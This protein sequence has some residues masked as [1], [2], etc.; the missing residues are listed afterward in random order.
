[1]QRP[2]GTVRSLASSP[3]SSLATSSSSSPNQSSISSLIITSSSTSSS[4][5]FTPGENRPDSNLKSSSMDSSFK[6]GNTSQ[7][8]ESNTISN[9]ATNNSLSGPKFLWPSTV[10]SQQQANNNKNEETN[11]NKYTFKP[12]QLPHPSTISNGNQQRPRRFINASAST[13]TATSFTT[14]IQQNQLNSNNSPLNSPA[15][16]LCDSPI[17]YSPSV[18]IISS[19]TVGEKPDS[20]YQSSIQNNSDS[21]S[22]I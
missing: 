20:G 19:S 17:S 6:A 21:E 22:C 13:S 15:H 5:N 10:Q 16:Y 7:L 12:I 11:S 18:S 14:I 8:N 2:I 4:N 9:S 3:F 1:M